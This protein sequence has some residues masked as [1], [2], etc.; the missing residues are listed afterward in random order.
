LRRISWAKLALLVAMSIFGLWA[1]LMVVIIFYTLHQ[2]LPYCIEPTKI[3]GVTID[4]ATVL[5]SKYSTVFGVPLELLAVVYFVINLVLIYLVSFASDIVSSRSLRI[6][7]VWRFIGLAI[8]PYLVS[9]ELFVLKAI[10]IYCTMMHI[11]II[12]DFCI[13]TY[14]LFIKKGVIAT[15]GVEVEPTEVPD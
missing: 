3:F 13:I 2:G 6:L 11:A 12:V 8:V 10:C 5:E 9:L 4:C 15:P 7:F 14:F 1:S